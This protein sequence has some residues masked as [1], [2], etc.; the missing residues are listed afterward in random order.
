MFFQS[1]DTNWLSMITALILTALL[2]AVMLRA[3]RS[4]LSRY[5]DDEASEEQEYGWK[6]IHGDVFR[7]PQNLEVFCVAVGTGNQLVAMTLCHLSLA[8]LNAISFTQRGSID[9]GIL[10][11]YSLTGCVGGFTAVRLYRQLKGSNWLR[12]TVATALLLPAPAAVVFICINTLAAA[13]GSTI[14]L[15]F[16]TILTISALLLLVCVPLTVAGGWYAN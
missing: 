5:A 13:Q 2:T 1:S 15:L 12:C 6:L 11:I 16:T 4:D 14:S 10:V 9:S 7:S 3:L 8:C